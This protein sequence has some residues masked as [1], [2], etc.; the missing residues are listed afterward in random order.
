MQRTLLVVLA[1]ALIV[2]G[3]VLHGML[4]DRWGNPEELLQTARRV[5]DIKAEFGDWTSREHKLDAAQLKVGEIVDHISREYVN[6]STGERLSVLVICGRPGAVSVHTPDICYQGLGYVMGHRQ[7]FVLPY[8][9]STRPAEFWA[10][11]FVKHPDPEP[12]HICWAWS[13]GQVWIAPDHPRLF[14]YREK[15]LYKL[16][17]IRRA[18]ELNGP[19]VDDVTQAFLR[20]FIPEVKRALGVKTAS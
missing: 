3:G 9:Q 10:A 12:L 5:H 2:G 8:S 18:K 13:S 15:A 4:S 16:Y 19:V 1:A 20:E 14:F 11:P 6:R 7:P 17:V